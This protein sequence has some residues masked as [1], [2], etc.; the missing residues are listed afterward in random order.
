MNNDHKQ[1]IIMLVVGILC[2]IF[3]AN[4]IYFALNTPYN[5]IEIR[6][7]NISPA[8]ATSQTPNPTSPSNVNI[9][10]STDATFTSAQKANTYYATIG[11]NMLELMCNVDLVSS[12]STTFTQLF[13]MVHGLT[14][15]MTGYYGMAQ[16]AWGSSCLVWAPKFPI[17]SEKSNP[18][19]NNWSEFNWVTGEPSTGGTGMVSYEFLDVI[20]RTILRKFPSIT[21]V[22]LAGHSSGGQ[23]IARYTGVSVLPDFFPD[24]AINYCIISPSTY[25]WLN[26]ERP[27]PTTACSTNNWFLGLDKL[28]AYASK[29]GAENIVK[30]YLN[31]NVIAI[32]GTQ[33][34]QT[35]MLDMSCGANAQGANRYE[36]FQN[37]VA[38]MTKLGAKNFISGTV[39]SGH[40]VN[41]KN[42]I[43]SKILK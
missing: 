40:G 30:N 35:A 7:R 33:D 34:T 13:L 16:R 15:D 17:A 10:T 38:H 26:S 27:H 5:T 41:F 29:I 18:S 2:T 31:R 23:Y 12:S 36:R 1:S 3:L 14:R 20:N 42:D 32:C 28:N 24:R 11:T 6:F 37:F 19:Q 9:I 4:L 22:V 8:P 43:L 25:L 39:N 21:T